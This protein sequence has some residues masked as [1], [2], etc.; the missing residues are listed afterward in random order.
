LFLERILQLRV[1]LVRVILGVDIKAFSCCIHIIRK[2][3]SEI[4]EKRDSNCKVNKKEEVNTRALLYELL[5]FLDPVLDH[6][7]SRDG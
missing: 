2:Y 4:N 1:I 6:L 7:H 3:K 5:D